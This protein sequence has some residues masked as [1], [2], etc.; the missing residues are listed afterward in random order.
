[1]VADTGCGM[2]AFELERALRGPA[3]PSASGTG[4]GRILHFARTNHG[5]LRIRSRKG[6]GTVAFLNLPLV[7]KTA[8]AEPAVASPIR[9][10]PTPEETEHEKRQPIAA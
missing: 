3:V 5:R 9:R 4:I 2:G 1:M 6:R 8:C 7:L 10:G